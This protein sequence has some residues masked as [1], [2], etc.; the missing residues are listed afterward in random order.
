MRKRALIET[1]SESE[2]GRVF[3][4]YALE[5]PVMI[6]FELSIGDCHGWATLQIDTGDR[7]VAIEC[8]HLT[9]S[10][11]DLLRAV[12]E[13]TARE[14]SFEIVCHG[15]PVENVV[16]LRRHGG[17]L[18]IVVTRFRDELDGAPEK[19]ARKAV[20]GSRRIQRKIDKRR[21][22]KAVLRRTYRFDDAVKGF[23]AAF[24]SSLDAL[25]PE[26]YERAW[27]HPLPREALQSVQKFAQETTRSE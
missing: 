19:L 12:A 1:S 25:G 10:L 7:L 15:E 20:S 5:R 26:G 21:S 8:S 18:D 22:K 9:D 11:G 23:A 17:D 4:G 27:G 16:R 6:T 13:L 24:Q 3:P 14:G 2:S